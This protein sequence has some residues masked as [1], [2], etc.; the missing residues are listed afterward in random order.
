MGVLT[1]HSTGFPRT[2]L[3]AG[4][5]PCAADTGRTK[6]HLNDLVPAIRTEAWPLALPREQTRGAT[7]VPQPHGTCPVCLPAPH[8]IQ[9]APAEATNHLPVLNPK[10]VSQTSR[11]IFLRSSHKPSPSQTHTLSGLWALGRRTPTLPPSCSG[12]FLYAVARL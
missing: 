4:P 12:L 8:T 10:H 7:P 3:V 5:P 1:L 6:P 9:G 11:P 2:R